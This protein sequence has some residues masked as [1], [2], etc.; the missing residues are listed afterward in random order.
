MSD[1]AG[2]IPRNFSKNRTLQG[3][4]GQMLKV[5]AMHGCIHHVA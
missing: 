3:N 2:Q 1:S 4:E 5:R